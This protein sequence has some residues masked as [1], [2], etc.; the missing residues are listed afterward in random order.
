MSLDRPPE[1]QE[2]ITRFDQLADYFRRG[3][4]PPERLRVGMEHEKIGVL[5]GT[6]SPIHFPGPRGI[7]E[8]MERM[9]RFGFTPFREEGLPIAA[10]QGMLS[11]SLEPGGQLELSGRPFTCCHDLN[12]E[13]RRHLAVVHALGAE[14]GHR[15]LGVGYRPFGS[16]ADAQW[17]PK[18]RYRRMREHLSRTGDLA[19]DMMT[20]TATVQANY[21]YL[22]EADM[23]RKVRG[24]TAI[25]PLVTALFANSPLRD[26]K[27]SGYLSFRSEVWRR[28]DPLRCGPRPEVFEPDFGYDRYAAWALDVPTLFVRRNGNY[29]DPGGLTF[30]QLIDVGLG[31]ERVTLNDWEDHLTTLFP[32]VR[33]KRVIEVRGA[34]VGTR[35]MCVALPAIWK[36]LLYDAEALA[37]AE[38]LV[39]LPFSERLALHE[40]VAR[41]A[42]KATVGSH[43]VLDLCRELVD[44]AAAGLARQGRCGSDEVRFLEPLRQILADGRCP[45]EIALE[46]LATA[47]TRAM[48]CGCSITGGWRRGGL[49]VV[50]EVPLSPVRGEAGEGSPLSR[51]C[52]PSVAIGFSGSAA[53]RSLELRPGHRSTTTSGAET[54]SVT[55]EATI[56]ISELAIVPSGP[57]SPTSRPET[58]PSETARS[59]SSA[60]SPISSLQTAHSQARSEPSQAQSLDP[61]AMTPDSSAPSMDSEA[62]TNE[63]DV[64]SARLSPMNG[65]SGARNGQSQ[66]QRLHSEI[67]KT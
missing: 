20:M 43:Q 16:V 24:A 23:V 26:G 42:L 15:W 40:Q 29:L 57:T 49:S 52:G 67:Q 55:S 53:D 18:G 37:A 60:P 66:A 48:R 38:A 25:S 19:L 2:P 30:R 14:L 4:K 47:N 36:G 1:H 61:L 11:V 32:E 28:V 58:G 8:L 5:E 56:R 64:R 13:L 6:V 41:R 51:V 31:D 33:L 35:D 34:D 45:A 10:L 65:E 27:D 21:D 7:G 12:Q 59:R 3:E 50:A 39:Q 46:R 9:P 63:S 44:I 22:D 17:M 62:L 54:Q